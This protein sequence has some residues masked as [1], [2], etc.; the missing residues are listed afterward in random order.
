MEY[1]QRLVPGVG[2]I[3]HVKEVEVL[4]CSELLKL[5]FDDTSGWAT[6]CPHT[7]FVV[8]IPIFSNGTFCFQLA[9]CRVV[10]PPVD[11]TWITTCGTQ[12]TRNGAVVLYTI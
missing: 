11:R 1:A 9:S 5:K 6:E 2:A 3:V 10:H 12:P 8:S 4:L 7:P